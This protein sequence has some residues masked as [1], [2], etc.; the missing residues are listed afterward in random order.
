MPLDLKQHRV[1]VTG[2]AGFLGRAVCAKLRAAKVEHVIVP[3]SREFD[4]TRQDSVEALFDRER[5]DV[6]IHL[7]A[8][9]GGIGANQRHPGRFCYANLAMGLNMIEESRRRGVRKLVL[10]GTTC[11]Y[12]KDCSTPFREDDLWS[13]YPESTNA[14]Y[15]VAKRALG[16]LLDAYRREYGMA[17]A[18][19]LPANL[20]G[21]G[22]QF[23]TERSH[24]IAAL[25]RRFCEAVDQRRDEVVCW[26]SGEVSREFLYVDDAAGGII[27]AAERMEKPDPINLGTGRDITIKE[28]AGRIA[29]LCGFHGRV[30][31]DRT[32]ADGQPLRR[33]DTTRAENLLGWKAKVDLDEGLRRT[34][35][36]WRESG[37]QQR[38]ANSE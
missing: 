4:L 33:L 2:G 17:G 23:D 3:R 25:I 14:P 15:G 13:G 1:C 9:V 22:D 31:W 18:Y 19:V 38:S 5:P 21:P 28:L 16:A 37:Q 26:G 35:A 36:W 12:P 11:S 6:V 32:R 8:E 24:V 34:V 7:A 27:A 29:T 30:A 10:I 20:Y